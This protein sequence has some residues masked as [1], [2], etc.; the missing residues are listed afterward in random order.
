MPVIYEKASPTFLAAQPANPDISLS[1]MPDTDWAEFSSHLT[2]RMVQMN[3]WRLSW[4]Q[5]W[6]LLAEYILPRRYLWLINPNSMNR[7][8]AINQH[9][10]DSTGTLSMRV[11]SSGLMSGLTSPS[12][13]WFKLSVNDIDLDEE[14]GAWLDE[15][16]KRIYQVMAG[17]NFYDSCAQMYEDLTVFGTSPMIIYEDPDE[18]IRCYNPCAGE[19]F[20]AVGPSFRVESFYRQF[21]YTVSQLVEFFGVDNCPGSV[22]SMWQSKSGN[23]ETEFIVAHSIEPNFPISSRQGDGELNILKG[24]FPYREVYWLWGNIGEQPLSVRGFHE[25][26]F[27]APRWAITANDPYGR[28]P[29]MDTLPDV[30]QLQVE[31]KRKAEAIEKQVRPPMLASVELKN[32]PSSIL[33]GHVTYVTQLDNGKGMRPTYEVKP[34]LQAM[35]QDLAQIQLRIQRGFF[36][37]LFLM[38]QT[39][40]SDRMTAYEVAARQQEKLQ[41]LGPVIE[42]FQN[43]ALSPMI[44]RVFSIMD[45]KKLLPPPPQ[46]MGGKNIKIEYISILALAQA[47][48]NT[49]AIERVLAT[50]GNMAG[51]AKISTEFAG[52]LDNI[53][54]DVTIREYGNLLTAPHKMYRS[55]NATK[56]VRDARNKAIAAQQGAEAQNAQADTALGVAKG[57]KTLSETDVGGGSN[58][59]SQILGGTGVQPQ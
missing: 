56:A 35:S 13:P 36:N 11:C 57:A 20:L 33:P 23:L 44:K 40:G 43:E 25:P 4:W 5:H 24:K 55:A 46:S 26:P 34:D 54:P 58:L 2:S 31:T 42:R 7:G 50:A 14:A 18:V 38:L 52:T 12:R 27:V 49:A 53:D 41:V 51:A 29:G 17:S 6:A 45:R 1:S 47:A 9:I 16:E 28:S 32:E 59:L 39:Q 37:D 3:N 30:M 8:Y 48:A 15:V 10:V 19:Y 21:V 22:Q